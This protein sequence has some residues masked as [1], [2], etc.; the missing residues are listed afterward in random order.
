MLPSCCRKA[1]DFGLGLTD[2]PIKIPAPELDAAMAASA[3]SLLQAAVNPILPTPAAEDTPV[4]LE[5]GAPIRTEEQAP[6]DH[7]AMLLLESPQNRPGKP[8]LTLRLA[9][10]LSSLYFSCVPC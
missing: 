9:F 4:G 8:E 1:A 10:C 3:A 6:G 5:E 2:P 7:G